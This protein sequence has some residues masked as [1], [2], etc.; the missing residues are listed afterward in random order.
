MTPEEIYN[1]IDRYVEHRIEPG[2][3]LRAVLENDL[4]GALGRADVMN[5]YLIFDIVSYVYNRVPFVCCG[6]RE[7][8]KKWLSG[9]VELPVES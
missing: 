3:F 2:G 9:S 4:S 1:S 7:K 8:V 6:S 5:R